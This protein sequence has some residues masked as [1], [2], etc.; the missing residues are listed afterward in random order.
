MRV[1]RVQ[2]FHGT[3]ANGN[4]P[5]VEVTVARPQ[6]RSARSVELKLGEAVHV[7]EARAVII[8]LLL[9]SGPA[10]GFLAPAPGPLEV[11]KSAELR[12]RISLKALRGRNLHGYRIFIRD[13]QDHDLAEGTWP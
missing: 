5:Y 12:S 3:A 13:E 4:V 2:G 6:S 11:G 7:A 8:Q 10:D 9:V 1:K